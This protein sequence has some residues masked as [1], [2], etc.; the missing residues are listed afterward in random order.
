[1]SHREAQAE[2]R[3]YGDGHRIQLP[4]RQPG[5]LQGSCNHTVNGGSVSLLGQLGDHTA[6]STGVGWGGGQAE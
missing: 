4:R 3:P 6:W 5:P 2:P 1:M